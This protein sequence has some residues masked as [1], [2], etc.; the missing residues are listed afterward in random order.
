[1]L[2]WQHGSAVQPCKCPLCR[3]QI[4]LLVPTEDSSR[5]RH[6]PEVARVLGSIETYNRI[7]GGRSTGLVQVATIF[8]LFPSF[9]GQRKL[10]H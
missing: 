6:D 10:I 1:M 2:V 4:T 3:R 5:Q 8:L 9:F 7:F